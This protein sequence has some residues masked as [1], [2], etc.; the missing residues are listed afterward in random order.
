[1]LISFAFLK[2]ERSSQDRKRARVILL[3]NNF[4][5][6]KNCIYIQTN[7]ANSNKVF[8][9]V[10]MGGKSLLHLIGWH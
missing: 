8:W 10:G 4:N 2:T 3:F 5:I 1:M 6:Y 7:S 9:K